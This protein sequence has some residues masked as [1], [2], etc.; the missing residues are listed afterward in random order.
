[1][2][3]AGAL[4]GE[5]ASRGV[6]DVAGVPCSYLTP[7]I[8]RVASGPDVGYVRA[9]HEGEAVAVAA[10]CWLAGATAAVIAQNSGLGNMVNPLTS[11]N[12]PGRIPVPLIVTWRGE[13][14]RP[15]EPQHELMGGIMPALLE[16]MRIGHAV[17][18]SDP[19]GLG[20]CLD[21]GW[22][23]MEREALPYAFVLRDGVVAPEPLRERPPP[24]PTVPDVVGHGA[25]GPPPSRTQ[26]LEHLLEALP[27]A[28]AVVSTTGKTSREL[29]TIADRPQHFYLVGAMG[30]A[31][32]VGLGVARH[33]DRPVVVVDGD[34]AALM[35]LGT[36]ATVAG[37]PAAGMVHVLLDNGVHDSTGGQLSLAAQVDLPRVAAACGYAGVHDCADLPGFVDALKAAQAAT[38]PTFV[39]LRVR[40]GS[41]SSLG[42]PKV[43]PSEVA[44]RFRDFVTGAVR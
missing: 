26:A 25:A 39:Y 37:H 34:G 35:R 20:A 19:G 12:H 23:A 17:L 22:A 29:Y 30:S 32:A 15:D 11:L 42:R 7:L 13:P 31:S 41:P 36:L 24:A 44:R 43:H 5:L 6:A 33:T 2:I 10:G 28:A 14:G 18:P 27:D 8:N 4:L 3:D 16:V 9:T 1:M 38:G 21:G 40:P